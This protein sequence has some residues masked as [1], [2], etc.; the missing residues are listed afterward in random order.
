MRLALML[1]LLMLLTGCGTGAAVG[2]TST[3]RIASAEPAGILNPWD[4][5][6]QFHAMDLIYEP[7]VAYGTGGE[8]LPGLATS[9]EISDDG[10]KVSFHLREGVRFHDG[11]P[12]DAAAAQ[13]NFEQWVG[14][15]QFLFLGSSRVI[16]RIEAPSSHLLVLHLS[17][18]YP[19]LLQELSIVRPFRFLS[20]AA[21]PGGRYSEPIGT[22]PWQ[23]ESAT[24]S[25]A[26]FIRN[27]SYWGP[28]P[29]LERV[30]FVFI[31]DSQTRLSA[32]RA[33]EVHLIGGGYLSPINAVEAAAIDDDPA[34]TLLT[35]AADTTMSLTFNEDGIV[36][37]RAVREAIS[38][39]TDVEAIN[40][41]L[42]G[43]T[44]NLARGYFPPAIPHSGRPVE[45]VHDVVRAGDVL[46]QAGWVMHDDVRVRDG[47]PLQLELLLVADPVHGMIDSRTIGQALQHD[48][49]EVGIDLTLTVVDGAAYADHVRAGGFDLTFTATYGAPYD[50]VNSALTFLSSTSDTAIW[51]SP[52]LDILLQS[53]L[54]ATTDPDL[55]EAYQAIFDHLE[56]VVAFVPITQ[57]PR[58]YAVASEV[59]GFEVPPHEYHLDLTHVTVGP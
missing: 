42:Y 56:D 6:G 2:P 19:P 30:E 1:S 46:D 43:G 26:I 45:R 41:V 28:R 55:D 47:Q 31:P 52:A 14:R 58:H 13:F 24:S 36:S 40:R 18:P 5:L 8:L 50:P 25:T 29:Q 48:L 59:S 7:L 21:A 54:T 17:E 35:G 15:E 49:R 10:L 37:D 53:A 33:G 9:W 4:F 57:P 44:G 23:L 12:F 27:D 34:L 11:T 22:G 32:L 20:P 51:S 39:A 3:L 38:L 16:S